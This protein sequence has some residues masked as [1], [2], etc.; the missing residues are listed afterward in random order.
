MPDMP[1]VKPRSGLLNASER[2]R[3]IVTDSGPRGAV[4]QLTRMRYVELVA[5]VEQCPA[6]ALVMEGAARD[7][8]G[9][10]FRRP[11]SATLL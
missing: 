9:S 1:G 5:A 8:N 3:S 10:C 2:V 4:A 7:K 11:E 6:G